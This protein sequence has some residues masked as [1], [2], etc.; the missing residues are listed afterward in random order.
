MFYRSFISSLFLIG[1]SFAAIAQASDTNT[2]A[3]AANL[4]SIAAA[5]RAVEINRLAVGLRISQKKLAKDQSAGSQSDVI[6]SDLA[7]LADLRIKEDA[8]NRATGLK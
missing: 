8:F 4:S 2:S 1:S 3:G 7:D 6:E 5:S